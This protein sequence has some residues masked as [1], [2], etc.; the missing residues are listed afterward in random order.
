VNADP[1]TWRRNPKWSDA[2]WDAMSHFRALS[3]NRRPATPST[4]SDE[5]KAAGILRKLCEA[6]EEAKRLKLENA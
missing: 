1:Q 4:V 2:Q 3:L 5:A 6:Q